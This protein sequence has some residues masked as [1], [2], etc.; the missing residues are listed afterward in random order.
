[1]ILGGFF[2]LYG[3]TVTEEDTASVWSVDE[4]VLNS[5]W[6]END[7]ADPYDENQNE[8]PRNTDN[9]EDMAPDL[10][11]ANPNRGQDL[12]RN[13]CGGCH[14][15]QGEGG[16]GP[17]LLIGVPQL[18]NDQLFLTIR[19]GVEGMPGDLLSNVSDIADVMAFLRSWEQ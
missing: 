1:M 5:E 15:N 18:N 12:Y 3:C 2:S 9:P 17:P 4:S 10:S 8:Q 19:D 6:W 16:Q 7:E 13:I 14:G 11:N